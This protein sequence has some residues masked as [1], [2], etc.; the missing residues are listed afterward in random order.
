MPI[1]S[2]LTALVSLLVLPASASILAGSA[3]MPNEERIPMRFNDNP[4]VSFQMAPENKWAASIV[5]KGQRHSLG[6]YNKVEWITESTLNAAS[7]YEKPWAKLP[8]PNGPEGGLSSSPTWFAFGSE[9]GLHLI[10]R[11]NM[12]G[13]ASKDFVFLT[14]PEFAGQK[15]HAV[16]SALV[17]IPAKN[18]ASITIT[19]LSVKSESGDKTLA[20]RGD[21]GDSRVIS[22]KYQVL[23]QSGQALVKYDYKEKKFLFNTSKTPTTLTLDELSAKPILHAVAVSPAAGVPEASSAISNS[24]AQAMSELVARASDDRKKIAAD[25]MKRAEAAGQQMKDV[26]GFVGDSVKQIRTDGKAAVPAPANAGFF[27]APAAKPAQG[28]GTQAPAGQDRIDF[29]SNGEKFTIY[30][31]TNGKEAG[32]YVERSSD[33]SRV[34]MAAE[35]TP[36]GP[37]DGDPSIA[38]V[39]EDGILSHPMILRRIDL[40]AFAAET[41]FK[42]TASVK[43]DRIAWFRGT[44]QDQREKMTAP[45]TPIPSRQPLVDQML[46]NLKQDNRSSSF[47]VGEAGDLEYVIRG[48]IDR[49]PRTWFFPVLDSVSAGNDA[50]FQMKMSGDANGK[51][52]AMMDVS[53][54]APVVWIA[55]EFEL[56]KGVGAAGD[57]PKDMLDAIK[58]PMKDGLMKFLGAGGVRFDE[59]IKDPSLTRSFNKISTGEL[60]ESEVFE[61]ANRYIQSKNWPQPSDAMIAYIAKSAREANPS[62]TEPDRAFSFIDAIFTELSELG[63]LSTENITISTV[64]EAAR[65]VYSIDPAL[66]NKKVLQ[67]KLQMARQEV[68]KDIVGHE[69][70][71]DRMFDL[72]EAFLNGL[73]DGKG[74]GVRVSIHGPP[75]LAK[76]VLIKKIAKALGLPLR[77]YLGS[78]FKNRG[79]DMMV[80]MATDL[81]RN[82]QTILFLDEEEKLPAADQEKMLHMLSQEVFYVQESLG[83]GVKRQLRASARNAMF[84]GASNAQQG[85]IDE[86]FKRQPMDVQNLSGTDHYKRYM[87]DMGLSDAGFVEAMVKE[88]HFSWPFLDR[89]QA[90]IPLFPPSLPNLEKILTMAAKSK[91]KDIRGQM[92][93][94]P[95]FLNFEDF[96]HRYARV[97]RLL[98]KKSTRQA[99]TDIEQVISVLSLEQINKPVGPEWAEFEQLISDTETPIEER[100]KRMTELA[101]KLEDD[102][103]VMPEG[104]KVEITIPVE[105]IF[106]VRHH[107]RVGQICRMALRPRSSAP[108]TEAKK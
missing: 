25:G 82:A 98:Y 84:F 27:D 92:K 26:M 45:V 71:V 87:A 8:M 9:Q 7:R 64:N 108:R 88:D 59:V 36:L 49:L 54:A 19:V 28:V 13:D 79:D 80:A 14:F 24:H 66:R 3:S 77:E 62:G 69:H 85:P 18:D 41:S 106:S 83:G 47:V 65:K 60:G 22:D 86:W 56:L 94:E 76:T 72:I 50:V 102:G 10:R 30:R 95:V 1:R 38:I 11:L 34:K 81:R 42:P 33:K 44:F 93:F 12:S 35:A 31:V 97:A 63:K 90:N 61:Y 43:P 4:V 55:P 73:H 16:S 105:Q 15:I 68:K 20:I 91:I 29:E 51:V 21:T 100:N 107:S 96:M 58:V 89:M 48:A 6:L 78:M 103:R 67:F 99:I 32:T 5:L 39:V 37:A 17:S 74:P 52:L 75:G 70:A 53:K 2:I 101:A 40:D 57:D 46:R 104:S 23:E